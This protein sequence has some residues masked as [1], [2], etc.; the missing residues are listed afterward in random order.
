[1]NF[2]LDITDSTKSARDKFRESF[3]G[4]KIEFFLNPH[5]SAQ[6]SPKKDMVKEEVLLQSLNPGFQGAVVKI[7]PSM[8]VAQVETLFEE[9]LGFH[10]QLFRKTGLNWIETT[11]TDHYTSEKQQEMYRETQYH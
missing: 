9:Q 11:R 4:L 5:K 6:G 2:K 10:I 3:K 7:S 1:M 8:T